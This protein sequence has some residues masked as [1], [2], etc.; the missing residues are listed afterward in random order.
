MSA[1]IK[2]DDF[3]DYDGQ[4]DLEAFSSKQLY[5]KLA[6][7]SH[8]VVSTIGGQ[9]EQVC[10]NVAHVLHTCMNRAEGLDAYRHLCL[11]SMEVFSMLHLYHK[12]LYIKYTYCYLF[13]VCYYTLQVRQF[14]LSLS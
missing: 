2:N 6:D 5:T 11:A 7:Q 8:R 14:L 12:C 1:A 10:C 9:K 3:W 4:V 13:V